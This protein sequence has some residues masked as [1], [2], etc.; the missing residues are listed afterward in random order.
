MNEEP[1]QEEQSMNFPDVCP[2]HELASKDIENA[3][4]FSLSAN[5][6]IKCYSCGQGFYLQGCEDGLSESAASDASVRKVRACLEDKRVKL[7]C[8]TRAEILPDKA[9]AER[10]ATQYRATFR[11]YSAILRNMLEAIYLDLGQSPDEARNQAERDS[12]RIF[13]GRD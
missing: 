9:A 6:P 1:N 2:R 12:I 3:H 4:S 7:I 5:V 10:A 13:A 8:K 11:R